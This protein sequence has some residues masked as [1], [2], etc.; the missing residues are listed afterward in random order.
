MWRLRGKAKNALRDISALAV[1]RDRSLWLLSDKSSAVARLSLD[2]PLRLSDDTIRDFDELWR[3]PKK[4]KKPE[5]VVALDDKHVLVAMD[6]GST[7]RNGMV[8]RRPTSNSDAS[9]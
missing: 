1:G 6:T 2:T 3:L 9:A 8:V 7:K 4:T 5:G